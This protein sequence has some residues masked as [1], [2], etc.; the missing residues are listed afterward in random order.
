MILN[1]SLFKITGN[2]KQSYSI[3]LQK[4]VNAYCLIDKQAAYI[5]ITKPMYTTESLRMLHLLIRNPGSREE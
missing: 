3:L 1:K 4:K 5:M 2:S